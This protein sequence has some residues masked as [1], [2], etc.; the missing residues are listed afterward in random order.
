[1][2]G[3]EG[4]VLEDK[5]AAAWK[6]C[7]ALPCCSLLDFRSSDQWSVGA[8][9]VLNQPVNLCIFS[10]RACERIR[11]YVYLL[12]PLPN[13]HNWIYKHTLYFYRYQNDLH[14]NGFI[15]D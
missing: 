7:E 9:P 11:V 10:G 14:I 8:K 4:V 5:G 12:F 3:G 15:D 13:L 1:M 6:V 2:Y